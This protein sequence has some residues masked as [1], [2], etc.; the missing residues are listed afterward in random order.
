MAGLTHAQSSSSQIT[1]LAVVVNESNPVRVLNFADLRKI[2]AGKN[3]LGQE[4]G[5]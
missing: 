4:A 3:A 1:E 5:L 2:F